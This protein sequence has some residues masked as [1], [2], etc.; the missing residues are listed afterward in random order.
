LQENGIDSY[1]DLKKKA[2]SA[3]GGFTA[4]TK[5]IRDTETRMN[6]I[7]ELQKYIG[8]YGKTREVYAADKKSG[9]NRKFYDEHTADIILHRAAKKY[10]DA[11]GMKKLL[12]MTALK[13]EWAALHTEKKKLYTGYRAQKG[14]SRALTVALSNANHILNIKEPDEQGRRVLKTPTL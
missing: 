7:T 9:W 12:A 3:S 4:L 6:E 11:L 1:D 10:F 5:K 13:Q 2:S 14:N 8:Q